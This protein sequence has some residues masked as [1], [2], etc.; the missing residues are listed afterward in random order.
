LLA[1]VF[2]QALAAVLRGIG[3]STPIRNIQSMGGSWNNHTCGLESEKRRYFLK[4]SFSPYVGMFE[5][6]AYGLSLIAQTHSVHVP[7]VLDV[8]TTADRIPAYILMEWLGGAGVKY[9]S[10]AQIRL[11]EKLA[12]MHQFTPENTSNRYGLDKNNYIGGTVQINQWQENWLIF[13]RDHRL[14]Y[15]TELAARNGL[16]PSMRRKRLEQVMANLE[17]YLGGVPRR[18]SL[19]HGDLWGGNVIVDSGELAL[20]D[21]AVYYGDREA[22]LAFTELFGGFSAAFYE[23]YAQ[24]YPLEPGFRSRVDLYNLYHLLNHLNLFGEGYGHQVDAVLRFYTG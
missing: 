8:K 11:G 22:E 7:E 19:L 14:L 24:V 10:Q 17:S 15:Q 20:I 12:L 2:L 5:A 13:F 16:M 1:D 6:E 21:P 23:G 3:D 4:W 9:V 18:P